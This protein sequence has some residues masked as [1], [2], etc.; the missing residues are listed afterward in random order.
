MDKT[1]IVNI[2]KSLVIILTAVIIVR[3]AAGILVLKSEDG[4]NQFDAF[5]KQPKNSIDVLF[6]GSSKVYCDISTGVLWDNYGIASFDLG[7]AEA[8]PWVSYYHLK[9]ALKTQKPKVIFYEASSSAIF[10]DDYQD[11]NWSTDNCY[12]MKWNMNRIEQLRANSEGDDFYKRLNPFNIMHGRYKDLG[13]NDFTN[14]RDSVNYKGFD[15]REREWGMK[16]PGTLGITEREPITGKQQEYIKKLIDL[17]NSEGIPF[18]IFISPYDICEDDVKKVNYIGDLAAGEGVEFINFN[19]KYD[20]LGLDFE[21]DMADTFHLNYSGNYKYS[22]YLGK[23]LR[24]NYDIPD[25]RGDDTYSSW[26]WDSSLQN[27][28]RN[29]L[30]IMQ[31]GTANDVMTMTGEGYIVMAVYNGTAAFFCNNEVVSSAEDSIRLTYSYGGDTFLY[32]KVREGSKEYCVFYVND[33]E[34]REEYGNV[35]FVYDTVRHEYVRSV[36][37]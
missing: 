32:E 7:G 9:E 35:M 11:D 2:I 13:E 18:V 24:E 16:T 6:L 33:K 10:D 34:Y 21:H 5:Y 25:R 14:V 1:K 22:D 3:T 8:G 27:Y 12:G 30:R 37:F 23:L 26:N 19:M 31:A 28:E 17:A 15:P 4:I 20:E 29:D 36:Y